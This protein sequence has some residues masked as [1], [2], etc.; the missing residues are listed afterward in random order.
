ME[1]TGAEGVA[2]A[3]LA[4]VLGDELD[5]GADEV[6]AAGDEREVGDVGGEDDLVDGV[7]AHE[8]VVDVEAGLAI[9]ILTGE[10]EATGGVGLGVA[11]DE[12]GGE[13][14]EGEGC[15][16]VDGG[17]GLADS[18]LLVD[19]SDDLG[20]SGRW[21]GGF[22]GGGFGLGGGLIGWVDGDH[23]RKKRV[24]VGGFG[25]NAGGVVEKGDSL[26]RT[27]GRRDLL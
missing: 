21:C 19:D 9:I 14:F 6:L 2:E 4:A 18:S 25:G 10:A 7:M 5:V 24:S 17:G 15:G 3:V 20:G 16:E 8:E 12:E 27:C 13:A 11:V 22:R 23:R 1:R 26:W